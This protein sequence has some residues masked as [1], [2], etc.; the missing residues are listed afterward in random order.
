[1]S[2]H[3]VNVEQEAA[4]DGHEGEVWTEQAERY[5]RAGVRVLQHLLDA[6]VI[7]AADRVLDVGCGTGAPT[8]A[9][10][11]K[12]VDGHVTGVDLSTSMLDLARKRSA[13]EGLTNVTFV[14]GDAQVFPFEPD[15]FDVAMS[16]FG[17]MFFGD[18]VAAYTNIGTALRPGGRLALLAWRH[19]QDNEWLMGLRGAIALGRELPLPPPDAP[20]PFSLADPDRVRRVLGAA[21]YD[22]VELRPVDEPMMLGVDAA[23]ALEF[24]RTMGVVEGL[25]Q[26]LDEASVAQAFANLGDLFARYE[27]SDGVLIP[28]ASWLILARRA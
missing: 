15:A 21:G 1:M 12:A 22:D 18:P 7:G 26:D 11:R 14:R 24:S 2:T 16:S 10:A 23:D 27:T 4:W 9:V 5:E 13:D 6:D 20:T 25:T 17:V 8:R 28:S 19:L 3:V